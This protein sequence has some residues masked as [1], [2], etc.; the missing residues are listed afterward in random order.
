MNERRCHGAIDAA[1]GTPIVNTR[2]AAVGD[3]PLRLGGLLPGV[4]LAYCS[5]GRLANDGRNAVLLTHGFTSSHLFTQSNGWGSLIGPGKALD[6]DRVFVVSSN[7]L[8]SSY[9]STGPSNMI[10]AGGKPYG[11]NFPP[12]AVSDI[13]AAQRRL[14]GALGVKQLAAVLG[15]SY[16]GFQAFTWGVEHPDFVRAIVPVETATQ[17]QQAFDAQGTLRRFEQDPNWNG[18]HCYETGGI[19]PTMSRLR[20]QTLRRYGADQGLRAEGLTEALVAAEITRQALEWASVF[21][22]NSL[23]ALGRAINLY[24]VRSE[25]GRIKARVLYVLSRTD[26]LFPPSLAQSVMPALAAAG[27]DARYFEI[28]TEHGHLGSDVDVAKWAPVLAEF[29]RLDPFLA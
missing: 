10:P 14:L 22:P 26:A 3:L 12:I 23:L 1:M 18:G 9:G 27:I 7:M 5:F 24:D 15:P 2:Y 8:G 11:P 29:L 21:D 19:V 20:E 6:T 13:V 17:A 28:D 25:L 4:R 16:G